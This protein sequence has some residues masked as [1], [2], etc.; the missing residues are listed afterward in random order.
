MKVQ[1]IT[2]E[3]LDLYIEQKLIEFLGDPDAGLSVRSDFKARLLESLNKPR[4]T[5][6]HEEVLKRF[7]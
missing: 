4:T 6:S 3:D 5:Y 7:A 2:T 1:D